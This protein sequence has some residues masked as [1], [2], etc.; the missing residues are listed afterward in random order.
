MYRNLN[1]GLWSIMD[2][3][4]RRVI[5][6]LDVLLLRDCSPIV[7][8]A[9]RQRV[10]REKSKNVHAFLCG[11]IVT[12]LQEEDVGLQ[13]SEISYNPYKLP[14]FFFI[15]SEEKFDHAKYALFA[16]NGKVFALIG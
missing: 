11:E 16:D 9:G 2:P 1:K 14:H 5:D 4:S 7:S 3:T 15:E 10:I 6:R 13:L 12:K 8:E